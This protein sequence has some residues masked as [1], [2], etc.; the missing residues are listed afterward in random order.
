M[1][2]KMSLI[3]SFLW[4]FMKDLDLLKDETKLPMYSCRINCALKKR[5]LHLDFQWNRLKMNQPGRLHNLVDL[6]VGA[7]WGKHYFSLGC[8][9]AHW[10][11]HRQYWYQHIFRALWM[12]LAWGRLPSCIFHQAETRLEGKFMFLVNIIFLVALSGANDYFI[13]YFD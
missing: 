11:I 8:F 12:F 4:I 10:N 3:S 9:H 2:L 7:W 6:A 13:F 5:T 1:K